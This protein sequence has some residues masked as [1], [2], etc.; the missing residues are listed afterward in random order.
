MQDLLVMDLELR[1]PAWIPIPN[2]GKQ[3]SLKG[4]RKTLSSLELALTVLR[5]YGFSTDFSGFSVKKV[6]IW[7][8]ILQAPWFQVWLE[9]FSPSSTLKLDENGCFMF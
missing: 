6:W 9:F 8:T 3:L 1:L 2:N 5:L 7:L 4:G